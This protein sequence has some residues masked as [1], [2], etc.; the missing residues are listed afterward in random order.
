[1]IPRPGFS[2]FAGSTPS[3]LSEASKDGLAAGD[4]RRG[5]LQGLG[6]RPGVTADGV[7]AGMSGGR[8]SG[9][10]SHE[11]RQEGGGGTDDP[12]AL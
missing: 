5:L 11:R 2:P 7:G 4:A 8:P 6:V 1:M 9:M 12:G 3:H 10:A